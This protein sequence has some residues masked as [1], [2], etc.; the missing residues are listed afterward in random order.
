MTKKEFERALMRAIG[1]SVETI[2]TRG[3]S[4]VEPPDL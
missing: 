2:R 4:L 3:F 1:E